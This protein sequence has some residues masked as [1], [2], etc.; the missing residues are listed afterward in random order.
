MPLAVSLLTAMLLSG[1]KNDLFQPE[2]AA[3]P[4]VKDMPSVRL[5]YR[6]EPDVPAPAANALAETEERNPAVQA[7][8]DSARTFD[9]LDRTVTSPDK[10]RIIAVYHRIE[11]AQS[12]HRLDLYSPDGKLV[13][14]V[15]SDAMAVRFPETIVWS[16]DSSS[17]AFVAR[18]RGAQPE[19]FP[20]GS[21]TPTPAP[22]PSPTP[23]EDAPAE[24]AETP[25][26]ETNTELPSTPEEPTPVAPTGILTFRTEQIY[27]SNA[28]GTG[29]RPLTQNEGLIYF[30]YAWSPDSAML[31]ALATSAREW[32]YDE[33]IAADKGEIMT[34]KGR[35]RIV[36]KNGRERRLDDNLTS[37]WPVWSPD[38]TKIATAFDTQIRIYDATGTNPTQAA[39]PLRNQL[40][41]SSQAYDREQKRQLEG[42]TDTNIN[43]EPATPDDQLSTLPDPSLLVSFNPIVEINWT[44]EDLLYLKTA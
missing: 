25:L 43:A 5:N 13:K 9:L 23:T 4:S 34:P 6:F 42:G 12:E 15:T 8:F 27:I 40:L 29:V 33:I 14:R 31:A 20:T 1:C 7:H 38:S 3:P 32:R 37:V 22:S 18:T 16:P 11:D 10:Q 21:Q 30:Y 28:D 2:P 24:P 41:I 19:L 39:I 17:L 35:P 26:E 44:A 36:E